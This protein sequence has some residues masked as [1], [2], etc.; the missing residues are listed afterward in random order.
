MLSALPTSEG[1]AMTVEVTGQGVR[2]MCLAFDLE[3]YS[4]GSDA[5]QREKQRAMMQMVERACERGALERAHWLREQQGDGELAVLPPGIDEPRVI[6]ALWRE[7]REGLHQ[8]NEHANEKAR[9]RMRVAVHEGVTYIGENG[10]VG[11]SVNTVCR[12]R[13]SH[14]AKD[15]LN[16]AAGDLVLIASDRI[17]HDSIYGPNAFDLPAAGFTKTVIEMPD[18]DFRTTAYIYAGGAARPGRPPGEESAAGSAG[19]GRRDP[20][21][22]G[23]GSGTRGAPSGNGTGGAG[24]INITGSN[25][26]ARDFVAGNVNHYHGDER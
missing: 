9:L 10:F 11:T 14:E 22:T 12:L 26:T 23:A 20:S 3:K 16:D 8:Y 7:F 21:G 5:D 25:W 18:K 13:D 6:V 1:A 19:P 4:R 17:Y 24:S 15:A 2:R